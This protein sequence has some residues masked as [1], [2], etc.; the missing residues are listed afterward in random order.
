MIVVATSSFG[1]YRL[2]KIST[3]SFQVN[4][5]APFYRLDPF[6]ETEKTLLKFNVDVGTCI[7]A[8]FFS[9]AQFPELTTNQRPPVVTHPLL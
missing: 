2:L 9:V 4:P 7:W 5:S 3:F 8:P 1:N 6:S